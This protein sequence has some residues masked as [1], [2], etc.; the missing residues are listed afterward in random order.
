[1]AMSL[2]AAGLAVVTVADRSGIEMATDVESNVP[3]PGSFYVV[4]YSGLGE[5]LVDGAPVGPDCTRL[6]PADLQ[7]ALGDAIEATLLILDSCASGDFAD[8]INALDPRICTLTASTGSDCPTP[9]VFTPCL[10]AGLDGAA[11][12]DENGMVTV[13]E[14]A[15]YA[16][17]SCGDGLTTPTW[18]GGCPDR[19]IGVGTVGV[20]GGS[21]GRTKAAYR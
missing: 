13:A 20:D 4:Y 18:D 16:V 1:M 8:A 19:V 3:A 15:A 14:A 12:A 2:S 10:Q 9:G 11:D 21:W 6:T 7:G 5:P 17:A